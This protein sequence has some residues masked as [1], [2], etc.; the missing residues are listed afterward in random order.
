MKTINWGIIGVGDVCEKKSGP[1]FYKIENSSLVAVMRR[2]ENK[3]KDYAERHFVDRYYTD[4]N[5]LINDPDVN[6]IYVATP[7]HLHKEY[8]ISVMQAGKPVYVEKP[9][10][11]NYDEC[12]EML[13]V[14]EQTNQKLFVAYYR[15]S[16]PYFIKVKSLLNDQHIGKVLTMNLRH[17]KTVQ[18]TDLNNET[19][20]WRIDKNIGGEGY[21]YDLAPHGLD[22]LD[23]LLGEIDQAQGYSQNLG[24]YYDVKDTISAILRFKSGVVGSAQWC[25][26]ASEKVQEDIVEIIGTKGKLVF[27]VFAFTPIQL[28]SESCNESYDITSPEHIQQPLIKT[29]VEELRGEG[30]SP[31]T[32]V[33]GA[34]TSKVMDWIM[35][36][37]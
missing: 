15:R 26:V 1:A 9:M 20:I 22:I 36:S 32:G 18:N 35:T 8:A 14:S 31:S 4:A 23:F 30:V 37:L 28:I 21:F 27:S 7:P 5:D 12:M 2:N 24:G 11:M 17:Y 34:R 16:L 6:A 29:I 10:A 19:H 13:R 33:T 3:A 25:F